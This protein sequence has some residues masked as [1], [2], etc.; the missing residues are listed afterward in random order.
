MRALRIMIE[1]AGI[2]F[3]AASAFYADQGKRKM[4][5]L[6]ENN[7]LER[8]LLAL[9]NLSALEQFRSGAKTA[10]FAQA[11]ILSLV[12]LTNMDRA[13]PGGVRPSSLAQ[14]AEDAPDAAQ[15]NARDRNRR[16]AVLGVAAAAIGGHAAAAREGR[17]IARA[18]GRPKLSNACA[19]QAQDRGARIVGT[20]EKFAVRP[21]GEPHRDV[22]PQSGRARN[23]GAHER[24]VGGPRRGDAS[25]PD[26]RD[27]RLG[28]GVKRGLGVEAAD[29]A[30]HD[31][32]ARRLQL[33]AQQREPAWRRRF[34]RIDEPDQIGARAARSPALRANGMPR[35]GSCTWRIAGP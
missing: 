2:D 24:V 25:S 4:D 28:E 26:R 31:I 3:T 19:A 15:R 9:H 29:I 1:D 12:S 13:L 21:A 27:R 17:G 16:R 10:D 5:N 30:L 35:T 18:L 34:V 6:V 11:G 33:C 8:L 20:H 7:V 32:G 22:E 23:P 14:S